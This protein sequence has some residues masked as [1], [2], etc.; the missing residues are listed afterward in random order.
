M[1]G[2]DAD[3]HAIQT[4]EED[5]CFH[6]SRV[7]FVMING[8]VRVAPQATTEGHLEWFDREGWTTDENRGRFFQE[9]VRGSYIPETN[10]VYF[11]SGFD[12]H[13]DDR[14]H[15][16]VLAHR[17]QLESS[18]PLNKETRVCFGPRDGLIRGKAYPRKE[19]GT[20]DDFC[21]SH[22]LAF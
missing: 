19:M 9:H 18:L 15:E 4:Q 13:F 7:V 20:W 17:A 10:T 11:Y 6:R 16:T 1:H 2:Q 21:H 22:P 12:F 5:F 3:Q 8:D 14:L